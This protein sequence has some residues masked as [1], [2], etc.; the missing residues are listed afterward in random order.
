MKSFF[1]F[2]PDNPAPASVIR[3]LILLVQGEMLVPCLKTAVCVGILLLAGAPALPQIRD[4]PA[5]SPLQP[6]KTNEALIL[7]E[8]SFTGLRRIAPAA[9]AAQIAS[10]AGDRFYPSVIEKAVRALALLCC[11]DSIQQRPSPSL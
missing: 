8:L 3:S 5:E 9:V 10:H 2:V 7:D 1:R 6:L 11:V 4:L